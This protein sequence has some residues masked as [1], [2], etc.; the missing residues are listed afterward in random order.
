MQY[1]LSS[2]AE[3]VGCEYQGDAD[4][5]LEGVCG[6]SPGQAGRIS[7]L[8]NPKLSAQLAS[9]AA[10]AVIVPPDLAQA[11]QATLISS[12]VYLTYAKVAA[13]FSPKDRHPAGIDA[14]ARLDEDVIVEDGAH[15]GAFV[16]IESGSRIGAG[17]VIE[18]GTVIGKNVQIGSDSL[19]ESRVTLGDNVTIGRRVRILPGAIIGSR[20][21]G[22]AHDGA[23]WV[24]VPQLGG[25]VIGDDVEIGANTTI[26][27]GALGNTVIGHGVKLDNLIQIAHN[28]EIGAHTAMASQ[29]GVA[30]S[31]K[32]GERCMI[33]GSVGISGHL[34]IPDNC[35]INGGTNVLRS[36][37]ESGH[38]ASGVLHQP[39]KDW[40]RNAVAQLRVH[41]LERRVKK[42]EADKQG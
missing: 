17:T 18:P 33:G 5:S 14:S 38:Y 29:C 30:G 4:V 19:I 16:R 22:N 1:S 26:D 11:H 3:A 7:F 2:L 12:N 35:V 27:R 32:I 34:N 9:T 21:F 25:V 36:I 10:A 40:R 39:V 31:T 42:L 28:V 8:S 15:I 37:E 24:P 6:I 20:G 41:E 23:Q 13:L